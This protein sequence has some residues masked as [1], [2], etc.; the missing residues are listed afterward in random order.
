MERCDLRGSNPH[1][2]HSTAHANARWAAVSPFTVDGGVVSAARLLLLG[3]RAG[4]IL[5]LAGAR[6]TSGV[7]DRFH[8]DLLIQK[9]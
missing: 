7:P 6:A 2:D 3:E 8:G 1:S 5:C 4:A 9:S